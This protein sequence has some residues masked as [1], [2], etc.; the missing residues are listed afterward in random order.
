MTNSDPTRLATF[1]GCTNC[2]YDTSL[3]F[4]TNWYRFTNA[5]GTQLV[6]MPPNTGSCGALYPAWYNGT[7]PSTPGATISSIVCVHASGILCSPLYPIS[8]SVTNCSGFY[9]FYLPSATNGNIRY[10]TTF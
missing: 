10:C 3:Y 9:V 7:Y 5:A 6:S 4:P 8:I 2:F 1:I